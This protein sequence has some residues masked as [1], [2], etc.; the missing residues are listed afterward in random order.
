MCGFVSFFVYTVVPGILFPLL[1]AL[2]SNRIT[3]YGTEI[4]MQFTA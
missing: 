2:H 3:E 1:T 4:A